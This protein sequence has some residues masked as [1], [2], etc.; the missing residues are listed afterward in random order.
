MSKQQRK[1]NN[2][3]MMCQDQENDEFIRVLID[4]RSGYSAM[5]TAHLRTGS[6]DRV[7]IYS[8]FSTALPYESGSLDTW[9]I[10][11]LRAFLTIANRES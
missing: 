1:V 3:Q 9:A 11:Y 2:L 7:L 6:L 10:G 5:W 8:E 4:L